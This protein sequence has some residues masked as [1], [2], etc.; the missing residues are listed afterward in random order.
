[1][2]VVY[3]TGQKTDVLVAAHAIQP[4]QR[5]TSAD[6]DVARVST[7]GGAVIEASRRGEFDGDYAITAIPADALLSPRM[8]QAA[9]VIPGNGVVV[10]V[11][12]GSGARPAGSISPGDIVRAYDTPKNTDSAT[13]DTG[14]A[15]LVDAAIVVDVHS[16]SSG[17]TQVVSLLVDQQAAALLVQR[18]AQGEVALAELPAGTK[19]T[20]PYATSP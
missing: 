9:D 16:S 15:V 20:V 7:D 5:V 10:G 1:A 18:N 8:F 17:D 13:T 19:P 11:S 4:G 2:L 12:V 6:F 3:R 14:S